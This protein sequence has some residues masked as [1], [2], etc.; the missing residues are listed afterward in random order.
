MTKYEIQTVEE[1]QTSGKFIFTP[2][3]SQFGWRTPRLQVLPTA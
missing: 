2:L 3:D 1:N